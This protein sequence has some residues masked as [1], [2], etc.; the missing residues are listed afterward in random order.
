MENLS[1]VSHLSI[2]T[3]DFDR[4]VAFY[5]RVLA[6]LGAVRIIEHP[7]AVA[8]GKRFPELWI[9]TPIDGA[10]ASVGNGFHVGFFAASK[11]EVDAFYREALAAGATGDGEPGGREHYGPA[12]YGCFVRDPDGHK[13]EATFWDEALANGAP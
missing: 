6:T 4:A 8:F 2:G 9:Q 1:I 11:E 13:I 5:E 10:P 3:N 12:Y 7:G